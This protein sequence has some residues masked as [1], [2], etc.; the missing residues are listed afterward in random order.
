MDKESINKEILTLGVEALMFW[1]LPKV[2]SALND[3]CQK[4]F[5]N[6]CGALYKGITDIPHTTPPPVTES[7]FEA[8]AATVDSQKGK[9]KC[10]ELG[11]VEKLVELW[12]L[13]R[14]ILEAKLEISGSGS[15]AKYT[16]KAGETLRNLTMSYKSTYMSQLFKP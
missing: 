4:W 14:K 9:E 2:K 12:R 7:I 3:L 10:I 11:F 6:Y 13:W 16:H 15:L 8:T 5:F 1:E